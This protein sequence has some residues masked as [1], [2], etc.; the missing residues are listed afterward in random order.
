MTQVVLSVLVHR[1]RHFYFVAQCI[2]VV[3]SPFVIACIHFF[4][5]Q[6]QYLFMQFLHERSR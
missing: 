6:L 1:I 2:F 4:F 3:V 5:F